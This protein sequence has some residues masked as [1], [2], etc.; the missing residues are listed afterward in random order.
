VDLKGSMID[1]PVST[2]R[3]DGAGRAP[4]VDIAATHTPEARHNIRWGSIPE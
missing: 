2:D 3:V 1:G 4:L